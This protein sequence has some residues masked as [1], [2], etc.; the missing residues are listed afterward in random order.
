MTGL[1]T[2]SA[3]TNWYWTRI[4]LV[5]TLEE[6]TSRIVGRLLEGLW[7]RSLKALELGHTRVTYDRKSQS[8]LHNL[9]QK[10]ELRTELLRVLWPD[11]PHCCSSLA[12]SLLATIDEQLLGK[13]SSNGSFLGLA[14][15]HAL[16]NIPITWFLLFLYSAAPLL[17]TNQRIAECYASENIR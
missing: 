2:S 1:V 4:V 11:Q 5:L 16:C 9:G 17:S 7:E 6:G 3:T 15:R 12:S 8:Y 10:K 14:H 13:S